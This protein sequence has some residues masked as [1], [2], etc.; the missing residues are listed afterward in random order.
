MTAGSS[1]LVVLNGALT[2]SAT[3]GNKFTL[4]LVSPDGPLP[5]FDNRS[6]YVWTIASTTGGVFGFDMVKFN[7]DASGLGVD[8]A[9]GSFDTQQQGNNLVVR[10]TAYAA[11]TAPPYVTNMAIL[12]DGSFTLGGTGA[13]SRPHILLTASNL[14]PPI[15]WSAIATN[16]ADANGVFSFT[17]PQATNHQSRFYRV[18]TP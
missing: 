16:P 4:K 13:V 2:I 12:S 8:P 3:P 6:N 9:G 1:D 7:V 10:F 15:V 18:A 11:P 17:D 5:G 14:V